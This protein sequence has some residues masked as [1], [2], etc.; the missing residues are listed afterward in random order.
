MT[1]VENHPTGSAAA[2]AEIVSPAPILDLV[3][4]FRAAK[5]LMAASE[6]GLFEA[7]ADAPADLDA[8]AARTGLT[9]RAARICADAMVSLGML[10]REGDT[11]RNSEAAAA[12]LTGTGPGDLR[13]FLRFSD[14]FS[15]PAWTD[16]AEALRSGPKAQITGLD[17][18]S[19]KIFSEGVEALNAGPAEA[20]AATDRFAGRRRLLDIGGGTGSW[21]IA[22]VRA[23]PELAATVFELPQVVGIAEQRIAEQGLSDRIGVVGG[24]LLAVELPTGHDSALLANVIH[25]FS[26]EENQALLAKARRAVEPGARLLL[27]DHWMDPTHTDPPIAALMAGEYA[28]NIEHGDVYSLDEGRDWLAATG[29]R[30]VAHDGLSGAKSLIVAEAV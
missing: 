23:Q 19:Q 6:L 27:V 28:V 5:F 10:V 16:L 22:L 17:P 24:D 13:P 7:L 18:E 11:Y 3:S 26:P 4:G 1:S 9:R 8:L 14:R 29:W 12:Y 25:C 30:F 21:S 15:Y 2:T 20:L